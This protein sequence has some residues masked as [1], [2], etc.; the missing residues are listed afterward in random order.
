MI[1]SATKVMMMTMAMTNY[2]QCVCK[3]CKYICMYIGRCVCVLFYIY[4]Y[5]KRE[6][7]DRGQSISLGA[8][9]YKAL[10]AKPYLLA[11]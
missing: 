7:T 11:P 5:T 10:N 2:Q 6:K 8:E 3:I 9:P 1:V 4:I